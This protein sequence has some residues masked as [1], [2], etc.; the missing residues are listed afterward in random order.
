M[1]RICSNRGLLC[2]K[3]RLKR[4]TDLLVNLGTF[5][6]VIFYTTDPRTTYWHSRVRNNVDRKKNFDLSSYG[7]EVPYDIRHPRRLTHTHTYIHTHTWWA[8]NLWSR[9]IWRLGSATW[10]AWAPWLWLKRR[11]VGQSDTPSLDIHCWNHQLRWHTSPVALHT[12]KSY[13]WCSQLKIILLH[14]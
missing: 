5:R 8:W 12:E 2:K 1:L 6:N 14:K 13:W 3:L 10:Y 9:W 11:W 4:H 7:L